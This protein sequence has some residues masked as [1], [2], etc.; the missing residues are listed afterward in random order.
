[1]MLENYL[2]NKLISLQTGKEIASWYHS[3]CSLKSHK[4]IV[5]EEHSNAVRGPRDEVRKAKAQAELNLARD[6]KG[7]KK[8]FYKYI[9]DNR[10]TS[11]NAGPS[12]N[13][14]GGPFPG[15]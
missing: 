4:L 14:N 9:S 10:K 7:S 8:G 13:G 5:W 6:V 15:T 1:M 2:H 11:E 3:A 12:A